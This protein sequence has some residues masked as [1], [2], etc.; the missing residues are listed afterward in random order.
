MLTGFR[1]DISQLEILAA[2]RSSFIIADREGFNHK[3][4]E[5]SQYVNKLEDLNREGFKFAIV[6]T[7]ED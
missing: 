5:V 4:N 2:F 3:A 1:L 6:A 7:K